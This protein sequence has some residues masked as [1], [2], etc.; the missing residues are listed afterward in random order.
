MV[1]NLTIVFMI[2]SALIAVLFPVLLAVL[3]LRKHKHVSVAMFAGALSFFVMQILIRIPLLQSASVIELL[4]D[5]PFLIYVIVLALSASLFETIGR[6]LSMLFF[7]KKDYTFEK[8][9]AHGIGHGGIEAIFLVTLSYVNYLVYSFMINSDT[10]QVLINSNPQEIQEQL[11][12]VRE[13]L[14]NTE[15]INF[16]I[17]GFERVLAITLHI[18]LS[19]LVIY[20]LKTKQRKYLLL[21]LLI[22][23]L[24][25]FSVVLIS[26]YTQSIYLTELFMVLVAVGIIFLIRHL[27]MKFRNLG[28]EE[29]LPESNET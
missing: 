22:H 25:D 26:Q 14:I 13:L 7:L 9:L 24:V 3:L 12:L 17:A 28:S 16:L 1:S 11:L 23:F 21:V 2:I 20:G 5:L 8:G 19:T 6:V 27:S 10:F 18:G 15:S 29:L 4:E